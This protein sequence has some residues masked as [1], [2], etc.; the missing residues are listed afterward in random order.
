M[1]S[2]EATRAKWRISDG[3]VG[4]RFVFMFGARKVVALACVN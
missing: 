4:E 2:G 3:K 1:R